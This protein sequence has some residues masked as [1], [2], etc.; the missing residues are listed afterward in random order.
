MKKA[1]NS[2]AYCPECELSI[3]PDDR[4][5]YACG[6]EFDKPKKRRTMAKAKKN[7]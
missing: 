1:P 7:G 5:C 6:A 2:G 3:G 4:G